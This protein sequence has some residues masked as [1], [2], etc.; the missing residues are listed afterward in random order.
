MHTEE[1]IN[2]AI[3]KT[4]S[5]C[6]AKI[7]R[8]YKGYIIFAQN[9]YDYTAKVRMIARGETDGFYTVEKALAGRF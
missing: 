9:E 6:A 7:V 1:Q 5:L 8:H 2:R 3:I 4:K